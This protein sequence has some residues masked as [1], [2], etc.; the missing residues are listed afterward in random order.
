MYNN[1]SNNKYQLLHSAQC[2]ITNIFHRLSYFAK[3]EKRVKSLPD[4]TKLPQFKT[5]LSPAQKYI[6]LGSVRVTQEKKVD[7]IKFQ[8]AISKSNLI[9]I[10][11]H[12]VQYRQ[13]NKN[14]ALAS[15]S[16]SR[17]FDVLPM[18]IIITK[19]QSKVSIYIASFFFFFKFYF[20]WR[21]KENLPNFV[22]VKALSSFQL[23]W[24]A[25]P[26]SCFSKK[27]VLF[28]RDYVF[29]QVDLV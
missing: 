16:E 1:I 9:V 27:K 2:K 3:Y 15:L 6:Q 13:C 10:Y 28:V 23:I 7:N 11:R 17:Y 25:V 20:F 26:N 12:I 21:S 22:G 14:I 5:S 18:V 8:S 24:Q 29:L 19:F 4:F